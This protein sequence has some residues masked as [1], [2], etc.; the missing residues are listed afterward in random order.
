VGKKKLNAFALD[1]FVHM[2]HL[3]NEMSKHD[4]SALSTHYL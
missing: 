1:Q 2:V 4:F 3:F